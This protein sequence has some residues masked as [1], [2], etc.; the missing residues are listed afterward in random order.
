MGHGGAAIP[1]KSKKKL[2]VAKAADATVNTTF[3]VFGS[4]MK[5]L[6][7]VLL[8]F[9]TTGLLFTCVFAFYVKTCLT[10]DLDVS[11]SDFNLAE[12][13]IIYYK[14]SAGDW[15]ELVTLSS[16]E[17]RTWVDYNEIPED[18]E[19]ALVA[20]EDQRFYKHKG[21]DWYRT[22]GAFVNM[23]LGMKSDFGG[24]TI[25]QQL[26][27]NL[28]K[29]DEAT[30]QRK[31]LEIFRAL[32]FEKNNDKKDIIEWYL[33]AVY[34]GEGSWGVAAAAETYYGKTLSE[35]SLAECA[36]IVGITNNPSKYSPFAS[37]ERNKE[38]QEIVLRCMYEQGYINYDEYVEAVNETLVPVRS[39]NQAYEQ[40]IY[41]YYEEAV[42]DDVLQ[43]LMDQKGVNL[44]TAESLLYRGG[45]RIYS[46]IDTSIQDKVD[47]IYNNLDQL[48][49]PYRAS[50]Q[51]LQSAMVIM[52]PYTGEIV[53]L[54]GGVGEKTINLGTNRATDSQRAPGSAIKPLSVYGPALE[55]GL[56]TQNTLVNDAGPDEIQ[57]S[58]TSWYPRNAGGG[59]DKI[60]DIRWA[61][62]RSLNTV[63]AQIIDKLGVS[64]SYDYLTQKLGITSLV[65]VDRDYAPLALGE[66]T[67]GITVREMTQAFSSF[68]NDG[69]FTDSRTY[70]LVTDASGH[71][72]LENPAKT[73]VAW[74]ANTAYNILNMLE[75]AVA[76]GTGTEAYLGTMP[77]AG[78]T[79]TSSN[80]WN[81]WFVG[82][83][84]YYVAAVW[85]GYDI[86]EPMYVTGN[87]A[88]QIW[89]KIMGPVH[90]GLE[91]KSFPWPSIGADTKI[92]G[93][94]TQA[95]EDQNNPTPSPSESPEPSP[96][97]SPIDSE[98]P[99]SPSEPVTP[100]EPDESEPPEPSEPVGDGFEG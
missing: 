63:A 48:P 60:V 91:Y 38:R 7:T 55:Y 26:I 68:V 97:E 2:T 85:T 15:Q 92:F 72:V 27:K 94:L 37:V 19:H 13:S 61:L 83:T 71:T 67:N 66:L 74:T 17:K 43:D 22:V 18:L 24:S 100:T 69:I 30:V 70:T 9:I 87:P 12:S 41:T 58:K 10:E 54:A 21:V 46:C 84:P 3:G 98:P 96:S 35:L 64:A 53:A 51:Q 4:I 59:Y 82:M 73:H 86:N 79:G 89:K 99:V 45:Y 81:R 34:F 23:F 52:N 57:L 95:L 14:D 42:I 65:D 1:M 56:I 11:L 77:V 93:D 88:A 20:I 40:E 29:F 39:E 16:K 49:Q 80:N 32:E 28:T 8:I 44:E 25:T 50:D 6:I 78:K 76:A 47:A 36:S 5:V 90:E 62:R 33:N 75:N 31:L